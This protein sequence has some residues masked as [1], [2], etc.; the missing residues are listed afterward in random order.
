M[1][2]ALS[3][4]LPVNPAGKLQFRRKA[5]PNAETN[6]LGSLRIAF[7]GA[8]AMSPLGEKRLAQQSKKNA[9]RARHARLSCFKRA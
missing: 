1:R 3:G 7:D 5:H 4:R 6:A 9:P 2:F 8:S